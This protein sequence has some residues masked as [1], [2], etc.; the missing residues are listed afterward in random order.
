M[1]WIVKGFMNVMWPFVDANTKKKVRIEVDIVA[2]GDIHAD[3]LLSEC[4][5]EVEVSQLVEMKIEIPEL[6]N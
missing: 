6:I 5:G 3:E 1:P 4:G 2:T